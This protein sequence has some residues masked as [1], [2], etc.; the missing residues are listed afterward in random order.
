MGTVTLKKG[1]YWVGAI[2]WNIRIFHGYDTPEGTTYNA[3]LI[4]DEKVALIDTVKAPFFEE[5]VQ[6]IE[7]IIPLEKIDYHISNHV[8]MDHSGSLA[9][10]KEL[11]PNATKPLRQVT[12]WIWEVEK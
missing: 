8:E 11:S 2:D 1:I 3:Y 9:R 12:P 10:I 5:M 4:V 7:E 6:R